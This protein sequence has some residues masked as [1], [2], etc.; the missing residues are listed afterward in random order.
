MSR[1][2]AVLQRLLPDEDGASHLEYALIAGLMGTALVTGLMMLQ[3]GLA[4]FYTA[5]A[6]ILAAVS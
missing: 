4:S 1:C 2:S 6:G 3:G 5:L